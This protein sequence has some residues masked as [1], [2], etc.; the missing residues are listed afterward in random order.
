MSSP[1]ARD[2]NLLARI[3]AMRKE[4]LARLE[5]RRERLKKARRSRG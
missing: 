2:F 1:N 5:E 3:L 4:Q